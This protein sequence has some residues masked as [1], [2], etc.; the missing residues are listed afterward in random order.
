MIIK[1]NIYNYR[2]NTGKHPE[3]LNIGFLT[4]LFAGTTSFLNKVSFNYSN[5]NDIVIKLKQWSLSAGNNFT[6]PGL[7]KYGTSETLRNE[8]VEIL[9]KVNTVSVHVPRHLKPISQDHFGYYLAG[10]IDGGGHFTN[11]QELVIEF[12]PLDASLAY[13]IKKRLGYGS[14]KK[15]KINNAIKL[16][17]SSSEGLKKVINLINGK[18]RSESK[19]N[20]ITTNVLAAA[21]QQGFDNKF[22]EFKNKQLKINLDNDFK[23]HWLAGFSDATAS[24]QINFVPAPSKAGA[25]HPWVGVQQTKPAKAANLGLGVQQLNIAAGKICQANKLELQLNFQI[26]PQK[27]NIILLLVK[28]FLGGNIGYSKGQ[29]TYL[30]E[31][32]SFGTAKKVINY[33]DH[34]HLLSSK[35]VNYLK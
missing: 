18:I 17:I 2:S 22:A 24:F 9:E 27:D 3:V 21:V 13:F 12:H 34:Y 19:L 1:Q 16:V 30:Y 4:L 8:T 32:T 14:V 10:L 23:N 20:Q 25:P 6:G 31:S 5:L 29:D 35:Q 11:K 7:V 15:L 26:E 28:D 33:F